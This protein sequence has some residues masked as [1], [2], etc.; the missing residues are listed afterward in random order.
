MRNFIK[1]IEILLCGCIV[2]LYCNMFGQ[3]SS[4]LVKIGDIC[5]DK[6]D[7]Y[8]ALIYY[9]QAFDSDSGLAEH[10]YKYAEALRLNNNYKKASYYYQKTYKKE[11]GKIYPMGIYYIALMQKY[12]GN[13]DESKSNWKK[14]KNKFTSEKTSYYYLKAIKEIEACETAKR[15]IKDTSLINLLNLGSPVNTFD[16]EFG[17]YEIAGDTLFFNSLKGEKTKN[18]EITSKEYFVRIYSSVKKDNVW[19]DIG[20]IEIVLKNKNVNIAN[21]CFNESKKIIYFTVCEQNNNCKIFKADYNNG[22]FTNAESLNKEINAEGYNSTQPNIGKING[23]EVLFFSSN[24]GS[25]NL[26]LWYAFSNPDGSFSNPINLGG[27]INTLGNE[28]TPYYNNKTEELYFSSDWQS[29]LG[30]YDIFKTKIEK[31]NFSFPE[32]LGIPFNNSA[33]DLYYNENEKHDRGYLTSNREGVLK[34]TDEESTCCNDIYSFE[35]KKEIKNDSIKKIESFKELVNYLPV[36]LYFHN[37]EPNPRS[38]ATNTNIDFFSAFNDYYKKRDEYILNSNDEDIDSTKEKNKNNIRYFFDT[39]LINGLTQ[40]EMVC[41]LLNKELSNGKSIDLTLKGFASPLANSDYNVNLTK[42]RISSVVNYFKNYNNRI[43]LKYIN[44]TSQNGGK[45]NFIEI[46]FGEYKAANNLSDNLGDLKN[47]VY[48]LGAINERKIEIV[49]IN[50][51]SEDS[52]FSKI[53]IVPEIFNFGG[54]DKNILL[55]TKFEITN[56]G[57]SELILKEI[58]SSYDFLTVRNDKIKL[59]PGEKSIVEVIIN[60]KELAGKNI[61]TIDIESENDNVFKEINVT[62]EIE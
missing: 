17:G 10:S 27:N 39:E 11:K 38:N 58:I 40:L 8:G 23:K 29:G 15:I 26:D 2:L 60:T 32:N 57:N 1:K 24:R 36:K 43:L 55:T 42:R 18:K 61:F 7:N 9:K 34:E 56:A 35:L 50:Y 5:I 37:D 22:N 59:L 14:V 48:S 16:S 45:L 46:P 44:G 54:V 41:D 25:E 20:P 51:S 6:G 49:S 3:T 12:T 62:L 33:N 47:A 19:T 4:E 13:Y 30:G 21:S 28:I 52:S 53:E 31:N